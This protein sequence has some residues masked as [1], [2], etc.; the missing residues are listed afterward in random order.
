MRI[1]V[2]PEYRMIRV[3]LSAS[4]PIP[5]RDARFLETAD[6]VA[7]REAIKALVAEVLPRGTLTFGGHPAITPL[8]ALLLRGMGDEVRRRAIL[9]QSSFFEESFVPENDEFVDV[10]MVPRIGNSL[11]RSVAALRRRMIEDGTFDVGFFIGGMEGVIE[12]FRMF[13]QAQRG[14]PAWP[15]AS[16]GAAAL[17]IFDEIDRPRRELLLDELTYSTLFRTLLTELPRG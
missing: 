6:V 17:Q 13:R 3:F 16:T 1:G 8:V 10:R 12:E 15:V 2:A 14:V 11:K 7:I 4:V 9:F 5:D